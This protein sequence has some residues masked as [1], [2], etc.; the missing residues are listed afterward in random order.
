MYSF[1]K[2]DCFKSCN[3]K[4]FFK[5][6]KKI[7]SKPKKFFEKGSYI[8]HLLE[9]YPGPFPNFNFELSKKEDIIEY[10]KA[11]KSIFNDEIKSY[12]EQENTREIRFEIEE[13]PLMGYI[14]YLSES[15][16]NILTVID[17]KTGKVYEDKGQLEI[18]ALWAFLNPEFEHIDK[19]DCFYYYIEQGVKKQHT[20]HRRNADFIKKKLEIC[21]NKIEQEEKYLRTKT[22]NCGWCD[23][24]QLCQP[25][26]MNN[27]KGD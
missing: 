18:Y 21:I 10:R 2:I 22:K 26:N 16:E 5:Y 23:Y 9:H 12:L 17:W 14:D 27:L 24:F 4:F 3:K 11:F 7:K 8:H 13:I 20:Y 1:S 19:V 6:I 15:E 25:Y